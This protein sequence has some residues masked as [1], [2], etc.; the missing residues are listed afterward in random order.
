MMGAEGRRVMQIRRT[1]GGTRRFGTAACLGTAVMIS[2][3]ALS[4]CSNAKTGARAAARQCG[5]SH[6]AAGV[7]V[8][9]QVNAGNMSCAAALTIEKDYAQAID[10][11]KAPGNGGGG[12]VPIDGWTCQGFPTPVV[13]KTGDT[14][15][16]VKGSTEILATLSTPA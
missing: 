10:Q 15:K 1:P 2:V 11:G 9:V 14:S 6:T 5:T 13:L 4:A 3:L 7:P 8:T 16:C 12:P